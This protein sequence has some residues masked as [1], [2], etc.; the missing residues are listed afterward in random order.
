MD[1]AGQQPPPFSI[2]K[3]LF[4][5]IDKKQDGVITMDE[6]MDSFGL[7]VQN[8]NPS[9]QSAPILEDLEWERTKDFERVIL[10]LGRSRKLLNSIFR[11]RTK[12]DTLDLSLD[13]RLDLKGC[14]TRHKV[15]AD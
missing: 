2:I 15:R 4:E 14:E 3:D 7:Y 9:A 1:L 6:W 11:Q 10:A 12:N 8:S 5:F 13:V